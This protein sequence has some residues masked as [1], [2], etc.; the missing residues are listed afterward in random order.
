[1]FHIRKKNS[2][3]IITQAPKNCLHRSQ[4]TAG[5]QS[6]ASREKSCSS[7]T[8]ASLTTNSLQQTHCPVDGA[9]AMLLRASSTSWEVTGLLESCI[10]LLMMLA[11]QSV[12]IFS[13]PPPASAF[14]P[15]LSPTLGST[16][17]AGLP[18]WGRAGL[19]YS[20]CGSLQGGRLRTDGGA[21]GCSKAS[22]RWTWESE[23][24]DGPCLLT[25]SART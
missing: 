11:G 5:P 14:L 17:E 24:A 19:S 9:T 8:Q 23:L 4:G 13:F 3:P 16:E 1:M 15:F 10:Y 21:R 2:T 12:S 22:Q 20:V 7:E 18:M 25:L 6:P